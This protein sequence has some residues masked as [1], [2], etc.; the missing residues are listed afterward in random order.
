[1]SV[2]W[3]CSKGV[4]ARTAHSR[5][6]WRQVPLRRSR[7]LQGRAPVPLLVCSV[8]VVDQGPRRRL[9]AE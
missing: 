5:P 8:A 3:R 2:V 4:L 1:M 6:P 9:Q 7:P